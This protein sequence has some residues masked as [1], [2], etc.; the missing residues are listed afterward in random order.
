MIVVN[1]AVLG[2]WTDFSTN[3]WRRFKHMKVCLQSCTHSNLFVSLEQLCSTQCR[4]LTSYSLLW[5][6]LTPRRKWVSLNV[7]NHRTNRL[8]KSPIVSSPIVISSCPVGALLPW[9]AICL[10]SRRLGLASL[11]MRVDHFGIVQ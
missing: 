10:R 8:S 11:P 5:H 3:P 7:C 2:L 1:Y 6:Y 4:V 9:H